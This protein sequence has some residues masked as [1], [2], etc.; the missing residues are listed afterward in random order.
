MTT[1]R[2]RLEFRQMWPNPG[3]VASK[4]TRFATLSF[5][6]VRLWDLCAFYPP[7]LVA[8]CTHMRLCVFMPEWASAEQLIGQMAHVVIGG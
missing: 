2:S 3:S 6:P 7:Y 8:A 1:E 4:Q 5:K